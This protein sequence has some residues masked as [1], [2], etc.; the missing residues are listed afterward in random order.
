[1][2]AVTGLT[3]LTWLFIRL[4][5]QP[6]SR[7]GRPKNRQSS[8]LA[9]IRLV[10]IWL[11]DGAGGQGDCI[12]TTALFWWMPSIHSTYKSSRAANRAQPPGH[13]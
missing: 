9:A 5:R 11:T 1:V 7:P 12:S 10:R 13:G 3:I 6:A 8:L 2:V 4:V